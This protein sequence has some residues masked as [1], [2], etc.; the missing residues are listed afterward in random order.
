[1]QHHYLYHVDGDLVPRDEATVSVRDRGLLYGDGVTERMRTYGGAVFEWKAHESRIR[2]R[3]DVLSIPVPSDLHDRIEE[4]LAANDRSE[5][6]VRVSITRGGGPALTPDPDAAPTIVVAVE[7]PPRADSDENGGRAGSAVMQTVTVRRPDGD[8]PFDERATRLRARLELARAATDQ[9]RAD[10]ALVRDREGF[11]TG[12]ATSDLL[13]VDESALH[14][15]A[16]TPV[17]VLRP[18]VRDLAREEDIPVE[19]GRYSPNAVREANEAFLASA[20]GKVRPISRLDG[21][22]IGDGPVR[23]LLSATLDELIEQRYY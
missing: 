19:T 8:D 11:V 23:K 22:A 10:E 2:E 20:V 3:C 14:V 4:T 9:Y 21:I 12:G 7:T 1:M 17:D 15:P 13:F 5:A 16:G 18:I 6:V